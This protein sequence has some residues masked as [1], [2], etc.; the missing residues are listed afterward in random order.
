MARVFG[1]GEG[2]RWGDA[3]GAGAVD[4]ARDDGDGSMNRTGC[5]ETWHV[6]LSENKALQEREAGNV[7]S[8]HRAILKRNPASRRFV[9]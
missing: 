1:V 6:L 9:F 2:G 8:L 7:L 3:R 5:D 4:Q